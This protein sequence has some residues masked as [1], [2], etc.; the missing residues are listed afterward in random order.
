MGKAA[1]S[2]KTRQTEL[3]GV[4]LNSDL[5]SLL[6]ERAKENG[7]SPT[8]Q[9][10][11]LLARSLGFSNEVET[12]PPSRRCAKKTISQDLK[13]AICFLDLLQDMRREL[14]YLTHTLTRTDSDPSESYAIVAVLAKISASL[15][16]IQIH[17]TGGNT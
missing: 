11:V 12:R 8:S 14:R 1:R 5:K 4:R 15:H 2:S 9:A 16:G 13:R 3:I 7:I 10:R 17:V 6:D